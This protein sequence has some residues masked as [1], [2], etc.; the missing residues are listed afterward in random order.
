M[1]ERE[2]VPALSGPAQHHARVA[3][4]LVGIVEREIRLGP[5]AASREVEVLQQLLGDC[6]TDLLELRTRLAR[7]L[8]AG[9]ADDPAR[10]AQ[11]WPA[12]MELVRADLS[13]CKP[14][15]DSW[16]GE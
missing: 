15:H 7:E 10:A 1:L 8:R 6:G 16:E 12:L 13:I 4:S 14:G 3:A 9:S 11:V 5:E 2:L